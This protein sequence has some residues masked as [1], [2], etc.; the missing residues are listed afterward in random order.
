MAAFNDLTSQR[1]GR[2]VVLNRAATVGKRTQWHCGCDCGN[3]IIAIASHL[4]SGHTQ[5]CGCLKIETTINR[6]TK[7]GAKRRIKT[8]PEYESWRGA[9]ARCF[10]TTYRRYADWGG[11]GI[12]MCE[13]WKNDFTA[14]L[15]DMG[16]CPEGRSIDRIDNDG[17]YEPGNCR[18]ATRSEQVRNSRPRKKGYTKFQPCRR[19]IEHEGRSLSVRDWAKELGIP[20]GRLQTRIFRGWPIEKALR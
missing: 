8:S 17:N 12:T 20:Y 15:R 10:R 7:H 3:K 9:K 11:R 16:P 1:F 18:W 4:R 2:L 5:S 13:E 19:F 14:F 6:S